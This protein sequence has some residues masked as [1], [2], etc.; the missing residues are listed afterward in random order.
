MILMVKLPNNDYHGE[1]FIT[2][3]KKVSVVA[4]TSN[5]G[6]SDFGQFVRTQDQIV[7]EGLLG[8]ELTTAWRIWLRTKRS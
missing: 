6:W 5:H 2:D 3:G 4:T 1:Q 7:R 8:G